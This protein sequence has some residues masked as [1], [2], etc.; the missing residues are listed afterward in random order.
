[1]SLIE[2]AKKFA[3]EKHEGQFR[4]DGVTPY[5]RHPEDVARRVENGKDRGLLME[6]MVATAWLHDTA[7]EADVTSDDLLEIGMTPTIARAVMFLTKKP[8]EDYMEYLEAVRAN[9]I[10]R[11]VKIHD[12]LANLSGTP[13]RKKV[14][15]YA[16][17][18][19]FLLNGII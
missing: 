14:K 15:E 7:E 16:E 12:I 11:K 5:I 8:G 3:T 6:A 17:G 1:M 13:S 10:A 9:S 19:T 18:L 2:I 4:F